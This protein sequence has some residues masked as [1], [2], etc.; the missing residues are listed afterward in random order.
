[1]TR[2]PVKYVG[3]KS[4]DFFFVNTQVDGFSDVLEIILFT[5]CRISLWCV[6]YASVYN[7]TKLLNNFD[8]YP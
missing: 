8:L 7:K 3:M 2:K 1:M 4:Q 5:D 6:K